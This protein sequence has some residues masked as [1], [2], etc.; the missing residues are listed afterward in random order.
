MTVRAATWTTPVRDLKGVGPARAAALEARDVHTL[1]DLLFL[2]PLRYRQPGPLLGG[3]GEPEGAASL[4]GR[5]QARRRGRLR[6]FKGGYLELT[7]DDENGRRFRVRFY[8]Q[9]WLFDRFPK[10]A[11][12]LVS[13]RFSRSTPGMLVADHWRHVEDD[14][15]AAAHVSE[16]LP[17]LPTIDGVPPG[18]L[19]RLVD[20]AIEWT[21]RLDD[22]LPVDLREAA[23][24]MPL[25][26]AL[27][28][29][30]QPPS[31]PRAEAAGARLLFDRLTALMLGVARDRPLDDAPVITTTD[32][33]RKRIA[34]R[35]PFPF[36]DGQQA[37]LDVILRDLAGSRP[38]RRLLQG[39]VGAG[40]TAVAIGAALAT[41]AAKHQVMFLAPTEP[42]AHQ[43]ARVIA[44]FLAGARVR[45]ALYTARTDREERRRIERETSNG[46]VHLVVGTHATL[47]SRLQ[48]SSLG[49][50]IVD[51]QQRFG[52]RQRLAARSK[53]AVPHV[54]AM[55][56]TP[57]PRSLCLAV[58]G[59]LDHTIIPGR[60]GG[61]EPVRTK[62]DDG[63][64]AVAAVREATARGE[65]A[66]VVLPAIDAES[67]PSVLREG[68]ALVEQGGPLHGIPAQLLHGRLPPEDRDSVL[69]TFASG[70]APLLISTV[71]VEVGI[72][73]PEATVMVILGA[74]RFGLAGLHQLRGRVGRGD[75][76]GRCFLV[77]G[78]DCKTEGRDRLLVLERET[79]GFRI[80]ES[81]L[82]I[83][84]P[85]ELLG[86]RQA[87]AG[88]RLPLRSGADGDLLTAAHAAA[89]TLVEEGGDTT[90]WDLLGSSLPGPS[91]LPEDAV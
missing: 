29:V 3:D 85:G 13:G 12:V 53:G 35:F 11:R 16:L 43:H 25:A 44:T 66:F 32:R 63:N 55:S 8:N 37:A 20:Q 18:T 88:G 81:D 62:V 10:G 86:V 87:G 4:L 47:S 77:P 54:L 84:G 40:K 79:D 39:D 2:V 57:I 17:V 82:E 90:F 1:Q 58:A 30:H 65:R 46:D 89:R 70:A 26:E 5:V 41:I 21:E 36:T 51:E 52:V 22:P 78:A 76:P 61:R 80:A 48:F 42:L 72:D 15:A 67:M 68:K 69:A 75:R 45:T 56:A 60:P 14:S 7:L 64:A 49:L 31:W 71:M 24:V 9:S 19:R 74:E 27:R 59:D 33:V 38:M 73:V 23:G 28:D 83:R 91:S 6:R 34:A 50:V